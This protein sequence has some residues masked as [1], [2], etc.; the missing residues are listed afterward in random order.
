M[1]SENKT[2][3]YGLNQ[4]QG[5]EYAKR[6]DFVDDNAAIDTAIFNTGTHTATHTRTGTTNNLDIP[7][8]AKNLTFLATATI[9][10]GDSWTV[11]SNAVTAVLQNGE[12]LPGELFKAG[13]WVTGVRLSDDGAKLTF[14]GAA[15]N[16][17]LTFLIGRGGSTGDYNGSADKVV[18]IPQVQISSVAPSS[19]LANGVIYGVY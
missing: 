9:A 4:W 11:N 2:P 16:K 1:P 17:N 10:D 5:N 12:A 7:D 18:T 6:Q 13:C 19:T 15:K 3:H 14:T 8:G